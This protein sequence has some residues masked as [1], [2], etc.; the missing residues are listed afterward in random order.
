MYDCRCFHIFKVIQ[1]LIFYYFSGTVLPTVSITVTVVF[2]VVGIIVTIAALAYSALRFKQ[3]QHVTETADFNF[4]PQIK[5]R[6]RLTPIIKNLM[7]LFLERGKFSTSDSP[8]RQDLS[9]TRSY[10]SIET[11]GDEGDLLNF[12]SKVI[13]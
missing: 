1:I 6:S 12:R 3:K 4:H 5:S 13:L 8:V 10:G 11:A 7:N 9:T 2:C